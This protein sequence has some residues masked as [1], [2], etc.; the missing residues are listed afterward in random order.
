LL[1]VI[2]AMTLRLADDKTESLLR[3]AEL[4]HRSIQR[5]PYASWARGRQTAAVARSIRP[6][7]LRVG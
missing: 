5:L 1:Y 4:E 3:R 2:M 7:A 6:F